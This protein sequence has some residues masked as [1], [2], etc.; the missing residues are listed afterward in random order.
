MK[1][2]GNIPATVKFELSPSESFKFLDSNS[3]S[4]TPKSYAVF[5][6]EFKP[7]EVGVKQWDIVAQTLLNEYEKIQF[8]IQG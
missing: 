4:M 6:I 5:N 7:T 1:N 8:K 2:D 3:T